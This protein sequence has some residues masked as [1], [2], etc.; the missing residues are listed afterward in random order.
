MKKL[1]NLYDKLMYKN[2][3]KDLYEQSIRKL[4]NP[5]CNGFVYL[6]I[7]VIILI[8]ITLV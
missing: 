5:F 2:N 1:A 4:N 8:I 3:P 7:L 6:L